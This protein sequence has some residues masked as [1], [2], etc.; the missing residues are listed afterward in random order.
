MID[1]LGEGTF[2]KVVECF[3]RYVVVHVLPP[4][5]WSGGQLAVVCLSFCCAVL[6]RERQTGTGGGLRT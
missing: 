5:A 2:G 3:D 1:E 6:S 4:T